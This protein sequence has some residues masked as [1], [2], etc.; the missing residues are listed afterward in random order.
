MALTNYMM[1][2]MILDIGGSP[3]GFNIKLPALLV[4]PAAIALFVAQVYMSRWWL[5]RYRFGPL[6]WIW[7]SVTRWQV[8]P[9]RI[10]QPVVTPVLALE[11]AGD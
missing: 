10:E 7:R 8:Q 1:Q 11:A 6:E 2:V 4:F 9:M 5:T 3:H